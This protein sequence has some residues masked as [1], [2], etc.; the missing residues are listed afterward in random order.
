LG[1]LTELPTKAAAFKK[2]SGFM[3]VPSQTMMTFNQL[4]ERW[5]KAEGPTMKASTLDHY[6]NALRYVR[7]FNDRVI[8]N[9][10]REEIQS[11][12]AEQATRYSRSVLRSIRVVLS[13]TLGWAKNC[14]WIERNPCEGIRLPREAGGRKVHR[15]VLTS[16]EVDAIVNALAEPYATLVLFLA[17][18]GLRIGEAIAIKWSDLEGN[19]LHVQRRLY[20]GKADSLKTSGSERSLPLPT[21]LVE[22]ISTLRSSES[23]SEW[24][25]CS[26]SG[27]PVN[28]GNALKRYIR[29]AVT[30]LGI[31]LGGW[32]DFRHTL[33]TT[34]RRDGVHPKVISG[35]LGHS[36]VNI[37]MDVYDH[38]T[39]QDFRQPLERLE[40]A[41]A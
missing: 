19:V 11:F 27:T 28:P 16:Q 2:L 17:R 7:S 39:V 1:T 26:E 3:E 13:L 29:P 34:L 20:Q 41:A 9:I 40:N 30:G 32:H 10:N 22:R 33:T 35:I 24:V 23:C 38:A 15:T 36:K 12:L 8:S 18:T 14:G 21:S 37:A 25:F 6:K 4:V 31:S 5:Q